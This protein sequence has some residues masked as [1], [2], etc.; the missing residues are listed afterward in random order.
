MPSCRF[1]PLDQKIEFS[2][3]IPRLT[4]FLTVRCIFGR[5]IDLSC[6][7][8]CSVRALGDRVLRLI[9]VARRNLRLCL[10]SKWCWAFT[11][12]SLRGKTFKE[13]SWRAV[14]RTSFNSWTI[15]WLIRRSGRDEVR[16]K[17]SS[18]VVLPDLWLTMLVIRRVRIYTG[19]RL[20]ANTINELRIICVLEA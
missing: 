5:A 20:L 11:G 7:I 3:Y 10:K 17:T 12:H 19:N 13:P 14:R 2:I 4:S 15:R 6:S 16:L 8:F 9:S 18:S 1:L